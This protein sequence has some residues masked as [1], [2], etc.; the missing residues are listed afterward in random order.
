MQS[1]FGVSV[2]LTGFAFL[3]VGVIKGIVLKSS[4]LRSGA[5]TLVTGG[6]AA[7]L[8]YGVGALLRLWLGA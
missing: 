6:I 8:A 4:P 1:K 5:V 2:L 3:S 7:G